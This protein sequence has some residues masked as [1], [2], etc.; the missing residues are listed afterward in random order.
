[1]Y[2]R[3][4]RKWV[5]NRLHKFVQWF[6]ISGHPDTPIVLIHCHEVLSSSP[7]VVVATVG[8]QQAVYF[9]MFISKL[10]DT[11]YRQHSILT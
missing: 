4:I 2:L 3:N 7:F 5:N 1:M 11:L 6:E 8:E 10:N 9:K